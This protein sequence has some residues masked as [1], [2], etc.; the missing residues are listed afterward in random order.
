MRSACDRPL[1]MTEQFDQLTSVAVEAVRTGMAVVAEWAQAGRDLQTERVG[2]IPGDEFVTAVNGASEA[3]IR[4]L[5]HDAT[6]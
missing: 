4:S 2:D 6:P 1:L 5:L 3:T